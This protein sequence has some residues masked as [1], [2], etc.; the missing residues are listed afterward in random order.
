MRTFDCA[1]GNKLYFENTVCLK[2]TGELGYLPDCSDLARLRPSGDDLWSAETAARDVGLYRK[3]ANYAVHN[4]C[5]WMI[6]A[7]ESSPLCHACRLNRVIPDLSSEENR[8]LWYRIEQAKR[9]L[10][11]TLDMLGLPVFDKSIDV[12]RGLAFEFLRDPVSDTDEFFNLVGES[13]RILT[14][15]KRGVITINVAEADP[16]ARERMREQMREAY[17]TLLGHFRHET[18][19]YYWELLVLDSPWLEKVRALFGDERQDYNAKLSAYYENGP[20]HEW[21]SHFIS[22]YASSHP[23]EDWAESWTHYLHMADTMETA[24]HLGLSVQGRAMELMLPGNPERLTAL[25]ED[26]S[27]LTEALNMLN[28]SMGLPDAYPY[29]IGPAATEKLLLI[30]EIIANA[31]HNTISP[32]APT[33]NGAA[34]ITPA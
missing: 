16:G 14:G 2:C 34:P 33:R 7:A 21:P 31:A 18:G 11:Y 4:V 15:H 30:D 10:V 8:S 3:C 27:G 6:P 26:W 19:H 23:W 20:S 17:R 32:L 29:T 5:N 13:Q 1:C 28:R 9:R 25:L 22:A 12:E 24:H